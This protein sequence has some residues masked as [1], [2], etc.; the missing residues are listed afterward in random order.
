MTECAFCLAITVDG[1]PTKD[2]KITG[3][4]ERN[5]RWLC[6]PCAE[7]LRRLGMTVVVDE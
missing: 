3:A 1:E 6:E 7:S 2:Y 5:Y 4:G